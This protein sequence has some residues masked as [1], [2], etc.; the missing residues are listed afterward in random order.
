MRMGAVALSLVM[1]VSALPPPLVLPAAAEVEAEAADAEL[2]TVNRFA[3]AAE[4]RK[5]MAERRTALLRAAREQ[6]EQTG[7]V[8]GEREQ[9]KEEEAP[10]A[11]TDLQSMLKSLGSQVRSG[12]ELNTFHDLSIV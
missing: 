5:A 6:A 2:P 11:G 3:S 7:T 4:K 10:A 9:A 12:L 1:G 8:T